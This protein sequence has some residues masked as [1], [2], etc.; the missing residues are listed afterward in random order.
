MHLIMVSDFL[1]A[2]HS[3]RKFPT[4]KYFSN[5]NLFSTIYTLEEQRLNPTNY[6]K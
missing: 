2:L 5:Y 4:K 1:H 6:S 3:A